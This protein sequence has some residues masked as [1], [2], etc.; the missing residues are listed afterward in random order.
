MSRQ[1]LLQAL[2]S[3]LIIFILLFLFL[4]LFSPLPLNINSITTSKS[5]SF[6]V[7]GK[8]EVASPPDTALISL[9]VTATGPTV[10]ASQD[11]L[12][13]SINKVTDAVKTAGIS[14]TDIQTQNYNLNPNYDFGSGQKITGYSAS[15]NLQ[16]KVRDLSRV[17]TVLDAA[18]SSGANQVGGIIFTIDNPIKFQDKARDKAITQAKNRAEAAAKAAGFQLG[19]IVNYSENL[20][21]SPVPIPMMARDIMAKTATSTELQPGSNTISVEVFL[22]YDIY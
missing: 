15:S 14:T 4:K 12:N 2:I 9:G 13:T 19:R 8:G 7:S 21:G 6:S 1:A 17:N 5:D 22:S 16:V 3:P 20:N 11:S 10:K 18:T